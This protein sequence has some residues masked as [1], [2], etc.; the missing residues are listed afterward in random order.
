MVK[1]NRSLGKY[2]WERPGSKHIWFR[3]AV[4]V[5]YRSVE[6]RIK[7]QESL[8]TSNVAEARRL[9]DSRK[10]ELIEGWKTALM[11]SAQPTARFGGA[12]REKDDVVDLMPTRPYVP[13]II[14]LEEAAVD[15]GFGLE[16][17]QDDKRLQSMLEI[18]D[19]LFEV[20]AEDHKR[21]HE[22]Q[23]AQNA[24]RRYDTEASRV[25]RRQFQLS[26]AAISRFSRSA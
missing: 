5:R 8:E 7:I 10:D 25:F 24:R 12:K 6:P 1:Q 16:L 15:V 3:M 4:P 17:E 21:Q 18:S 13:S 11:S 14:E 23:L 26:H 9:R 20:Y 22:V 19:S 2:L